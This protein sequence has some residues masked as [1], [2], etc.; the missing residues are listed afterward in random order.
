MTCLSIKLSSK[1]STNFST[2]LLTLDCSMTLRLINDVIKP[3][4]ELNS[5]LVQRLAL[6]PDLSDI[7]RLA[8]AL[9]VS[10]KHQADLRGVP[11]NAVDSA[12]NENRII[13]DVADATKHGQLRDSSR[14]N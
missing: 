12:S 10:I 6:Q 1:L 7:T 9:A 2:N 11:R 8:S 4:E 14:N 13:S 5:L 3:W